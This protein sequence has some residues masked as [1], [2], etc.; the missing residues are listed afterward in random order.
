[1]NFHPVILMCND[2]RK[3]YKVETCRVYLYFLERNTNGKN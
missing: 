1:M 2:V 3:A